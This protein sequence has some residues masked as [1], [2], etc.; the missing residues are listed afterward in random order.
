MPSKHLIVTDI[1][2]ESSN[3]SG[4]SNHQDSIFYIFSRI[5]I[6][7]TGRI[8]NHISIKFHSRTRNYLKYGKVG[9]I[10]TLMSNWKCSSEAEQDPVKVK[11]EI[12]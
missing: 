9:S 1:E 4:S 8:K 11:V 12:S 2:N 6:G 10:P 7:R 5:D 3:L